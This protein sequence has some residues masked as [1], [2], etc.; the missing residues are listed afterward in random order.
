MGFENILKKYFDK[1]YTEVDFVKKTYN[2][3]KGYGF[4]EENSIA[5]VCLCRDEISQSLRSIIKHMWGEAF[6]LSSLAGM[7][8]AGQ[9]GLAAAMHHSP[10]IGGKERYVFYSLPHIAIDAD[11]RIGVCKRVGR[12]GE[13][14]A[15]G[16]LVAFQKELSEGKLNLSM[17]DMDIEQNLLKR[18]LLREI[19]YGHVP[20][21]LELTKI[22]QRV[23]QKD[24]E[25]A[26]NSIVDRRKSDYAVISGVQIH[27]PEHN[28]VWVA[29]SYAVVNE[30][31]EKIEI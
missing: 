25:Y 12:Q 31:M 2:A 28:Y 8:F 6:N 20:D 27:G 29:S 3:L 7:F 14:T 1:V 5:S 18:R 4:T 11:G 26:L 24:I 13:S 23:V 10:N 9:T 16:A 30:V 15:C 21:L 17:D 19:P 22:T